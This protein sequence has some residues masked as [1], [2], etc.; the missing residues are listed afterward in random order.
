V[1]YFL[2]R[3]QAGEVSVLPAPFA[4]ALETR[5]HCEIAVGAIRID[6]VSFPKRNVPAIRA[7][8]LPSSKDFSP[9]FGEICATLHGFLWRDPRG[10]ATLDLPSPPRRPHP[11][12]ERRP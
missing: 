10:V 8:G 6:A 4:F 7:D 1:L 2:A 12:H 5:A 3:A 11:E 9:V